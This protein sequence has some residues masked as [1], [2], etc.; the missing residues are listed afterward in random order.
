MPKLF[1]VKV[2]EKLLHISF[3]NVWFPFGLSTLT[4]LW[5]PYNKEHIA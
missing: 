2:S 4:V 5:E 1:L 3:E